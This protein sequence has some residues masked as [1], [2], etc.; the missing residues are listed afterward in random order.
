VRINTEIVHRSDADVFQPVRKA[1]PGSD[2]YCEVVLGS[3]V[4]LAQGM[5]HRDWPGTQESSPSPP[6]PGRRLWNGSGGT[7]NQ[8]STGGSTEGWLSSLTTP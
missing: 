1:A 2:R 7:C 6:T 3:A 8:G 4:S 5:F